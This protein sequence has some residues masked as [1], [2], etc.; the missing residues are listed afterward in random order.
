MSL[1]RLTRR[2]SVEDSVLLSPMLIVL[3]IVGFY[4]ISS[5]KI[6]NEYERGGGVPARQA[7]D[8]AEGARA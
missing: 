1:T 8:A 4:L 2:T 5:I 7:A 6:L 3:V